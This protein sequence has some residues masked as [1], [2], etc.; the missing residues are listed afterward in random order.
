MN[1]GLFNIIFK[2]KT[3]V[4][5]KLSEL[6]VKDIRDTCD[7]HTDG[8]FGGCL[9]NCPFRL[10]MGFNY[11]LNKELHT[12]YCKVNSYYR[13]KHPNEEVEF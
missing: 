1:I 6:T 2:E 4:K 9:M 12:T 5:K 13:T 8:F 3:Q 11:R 10:S 7:E